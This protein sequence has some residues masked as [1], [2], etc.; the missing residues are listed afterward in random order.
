MDN[1]PNEEVKL[2][3]SE[4]QDFNKLVQE[5]IQMDHNM[6]KLEAHV[7]EMK[8]K[9]KVLTPV[10]LDF[11]SSRKITEC[12]NEAGSLKRSKSLRTKPLYKVSIRAKMIDF[13]KNIEQGDKATKFLLENREKEEVLTLKRTF[14]RAGKTK[15]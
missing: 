1:K 8:N 2:D 3:P 9:K 14:K 13:F 6:R 10:I 5:W 15:E 12:N 7:K 4:V 11:M